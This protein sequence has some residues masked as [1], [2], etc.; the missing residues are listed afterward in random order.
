MVDIQTDSPVPAFEM[1]P[2]PGPKQTAALHT[3]EEAPRL[4]ADGRRCAIYYYSLYIL[5]NM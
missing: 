2:P 1:N 4:P 5:H 3:R